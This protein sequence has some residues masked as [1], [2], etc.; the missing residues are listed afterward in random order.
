[1]P[2]DRR[3][4]L[5]LA[6]AAVLLAAAGA[7]WF[8]RS[9]QHV[10]RDPGVVYRDPTTLDNLLKRANEAERAGDRATAV[11]TYRFV[12]ATGGGSAGAGAG[13]GEWAPYVA[14]ARAGLKRLGVAD[15]LSG[16][17]R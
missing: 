3:V 1:M 5:A 14:A 9:A 7:L 16:P 11:A 10:R 4:G 13:G 12:I 17:Q 15:T 2:A 8:V 6:G